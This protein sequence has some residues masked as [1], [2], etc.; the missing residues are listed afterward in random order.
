MNWIKASETKPKLI[1]RKE[2]VEE[3]GCYSEYSDFVLVNVA[4][5]YYVMRYIV[6]YDSSGNMEQSRWVDADYLSDFGEQ[7]VEFWSEFDKIK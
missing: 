3:L 2:C 5:K 4:E 7:E 6:D 1:S